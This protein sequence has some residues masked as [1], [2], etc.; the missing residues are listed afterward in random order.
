VYRTAVPG[1]IASMAA[2]L[3]G[4]NRAGVRDIFPL[5]AFDFFGQTLETNSGIL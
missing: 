5:S 3:S 1:L 2:A 4:D